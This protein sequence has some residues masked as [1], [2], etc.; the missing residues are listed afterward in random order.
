M[1]MHRFISA[2]RITVTAQKYKEI[3]RNV[4]KYWGGALPFTFAS[5]PIITFFLS[6]VIA[7]GCIHCV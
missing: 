4:F 2:R 6:S 3:V 5:L 1:L 7:E